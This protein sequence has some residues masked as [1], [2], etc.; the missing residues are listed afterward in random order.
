[1]SN[2]YMIQVARS[3]LLYIDLGWD[4]DAGSLCVG[5][6]GL[7]SELNSPVPGPNSSGCLT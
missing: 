1:M 4:S 6:E 2:E 7:H 5:N 3:A